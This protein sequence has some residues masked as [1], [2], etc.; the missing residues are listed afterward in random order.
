[1]LPAGIALYGLGLAL[2][3]GDALAPFHAQEVW[4]RHFAGPYVGAWDGMR[5]A[6]EGARQLLSFQHNHVFYP[7]AA[8]SPSVAAGHNLVL[9]AFLIAAVVA[10]VG[11]ARRM[12]VAYGAYVVAAL[13]VPL[14]YP[15]LAQ[16][17]MSLPRFLLPLFPLYWAAASWT[18]DHPLRHE[19]YLVA[20][21]VLL[22]I[23]L[24]LF[25]NWYYVF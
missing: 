14:S 22:G 17:L 20:S 25:I 9:L 3:G 16:P 1:M 10:V 11:V 24:L 15:V 7:A 23:L 21:S 5:A 8:G 2:Y 12:P 6:F 13:A 4:G 19:V 18:R